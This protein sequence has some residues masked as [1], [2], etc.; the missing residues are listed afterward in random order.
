MCWTP[1]RCRPALRW[2]DRVC[3]VTDRHAADRVRNE[4]PLL[5]LHSLGKADA[6]QG[7]D[8]HGLWQ[9]FVNR[10]HVTVFVRFMCCSSQHAYGL[11]LQRM[12]AAARAAAAAPDPPSRVCESGFLFDHMLPPSQRAWDLLLQPAPAAALAAAAAPNAIAI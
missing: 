7:G 5:G 6:K 12:P 4:W 3:L 10:A 2:S 1:A 11:L 8:P 9:V